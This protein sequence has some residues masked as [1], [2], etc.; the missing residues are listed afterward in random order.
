MN[1]AQLPRDFFGEDRPDNMADIID[2]AINNDDLFLL[3]ADGQISKCAYSSLPES[4]TRCDDPFPYQDARDGRPSGVLMEETFFSEIYFSPPPGPSI[5]MLDP[6]Q[7]AIYY[8][9][10]RMAM[11]S[12]YRPAGLLSDQPASAFAVNVQRL[13][14]LAIGNQIYY[15]ALP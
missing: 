6:Q 2:M 15:A 13:V 7:Q 8:F 12:Q 4:P 10:K 9:S 11:Q 3:H 14:F 5:Y 1:V